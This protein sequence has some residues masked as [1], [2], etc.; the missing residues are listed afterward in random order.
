MDL[1]SLQADIECDEG[2]SLVVYNDSLGNPTI[3][4]GRC[5]SKEGITITE[6]KYLL[7]NDCLFVSDWLDDNYSWFVNLTSERQIALG[8]M[9][10]NLGPAGLSK[11]THMIAALAKG[12]YETASSEILNSAAAKELP[13]RYAR[14]AQAI[15]TG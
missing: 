3:G 7:S 10:Y 6:A 8:N 2:L 11:F 12:D 9:C 5:L 14:L 1:V 15:R 13:A 4:Y